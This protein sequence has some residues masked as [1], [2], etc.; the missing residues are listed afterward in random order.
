MLKGQ[1]GIPNNP[2]GGGSGGQPPM[3][4]P[5]A[6]CFEQPNTEEPWIA[7]MDWNSWHG[8]STGWAAGWLSE[9]P[10]QL[11]ALNGPDLHSFL[12]PA[13]GDAHV[14]VRLCEIAEGIDQ[15]AISPPTVLNMSFGRLF[16]SDAIDG[17]CDQEE[18]SCQ[19]GQVIDH[20]AEAGVVPVAAAGNHGSPQFPASYETVLSAGT[21]DLARFG[22]SFEVAGS[23][24]S[25]I[26][27]H[28]FLPGYGV[29]LTYR[30]PEGFQQ[31]WPA[32]PGSSYSSALLAGWLGDILSTK[33]IEQPLEIDWEIAWSS[34]DDC[35]LLS[36][37][38]PQRCN[39]QVQSVLEGIFSQGEGCWSGSIEEPSLTVTAAGASPERDVLDNIP[40]F[41]EWVNNHHRPDPSSDPCVPCATGGAEQASFGELGSN[42]NG[43]RQEGDMVLNLSSSSPLRPNFYYDTLYLRTGGDQA[44]APGWQA[45][46]DSVHFIPC[47][48]FVTCNIHPD[49]SEPV[50]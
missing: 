22:T 35:F 5:N 13:V 21:L 38:V 8:W 24:E 27:P 47:S 46:I 9:L 49:R 34:S 1:I 14:L 12:S 26:G 28:V 16:D 29:C 50:S 31:L 15:R 19:V 44:R 37:D 45:P 41:D 25:P 30:D 32:P 33:N 2:G 39:L 43:N 17:S 48:S 23:W 11:Y 18:L 10:V 6:S 3:P 36:P 42:K 4:C 7:V 40:S 20:L